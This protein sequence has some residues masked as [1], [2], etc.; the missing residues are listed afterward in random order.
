MKI[1]YLAHRIPYPP[2]KGDKIRSFHEIRYFGRRHE[3]H[4]LA[5][6]DQPGD[7]AYATKLSE[8]C[9]R[10]TL[11]PLSHWPQRFRAATAMLL[12]K[13]WTLGYFANPAMRN[14][15]DRELLEDSFDLVFAYS[16]S[17]APYIAPLGGLPRILD[18]VDS[19][20]SKWRQYARM[21]SVPSKWLYDFEWRKL[22]KYEAETISHL[23]SSIFVSPREARHLAKIVDAGK[24]CFIQ[25]GV[26]LG[27]FS[28]VPRAGSSRSII[29]TGAMDYFPNIEAVN[30]FARE[31]LP[32]VHAAIP[33]TQFLIVGSN[34][35]RQVRML[36]DLP[37]VIVTGTVK[38]VRPYL[39]EA[40]VSVVPV[41]VSQGIQNKILEA[42]ASG[43]PVV[44]TRAALGGMASTR[45]LPVAEADDAPAFAEH[46]IKFLKNPLTNGQIETCRRMLKLN[47]DWD[48]N[49]SAF[50]RLFERLVPSHSTV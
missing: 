13:P 33:D 5:F 46:V 11:V 27:Y 28:A 14:A 43:L 40:G 48:T 42:L 21:G 8:Y 50:E 49:L 10:V 34:P 37:G 26:D 18:F 7:G 12:G 22:N 20:A 15:L 41:K 4:L 1:L 9:R 2:N 44:A 16:S 30:F 24:L 29:F 45:D 3:V 17:M 25:N 36:A 47:Y 38:D 6:C 32:I 35:S 23:D 31:V 39:S 19:D